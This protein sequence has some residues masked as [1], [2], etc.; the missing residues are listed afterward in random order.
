MNFNTLEFALFFPMVLV[1]LS[2][3]FR[4][5]RLRDGLLLLVSYLFYMAWYWQY[6]GLLVLSTLIDY[7]LGRRMET[8]QDPRRRKL[9]LS[10][11]L[12]LNLGILGFFK[13]YNFFTGLAS[14]SFRFFGYP[15]DFLRNPWLLPVGISFY[16]FQSLSYTI[17]VYRRR[18]PAEHSLVKFALFVAFFPQLVAG[19]IVRAADF[20]P[21][22]HRPLVVGRGRF[23]RGLTLIFIGLF[24]KIVFADALAS[25]GVD[26]VFDHPAG[27][28]SL[29][30]LMALY[31]YAFQIYCDFSGYSDIAIG[32][33]AMMGFWLPANFNRPYL[34]QNLREFWTR[35]H[36]SLS[37]WLK[38]YLYL[39]LGGN[40]GTP[41]Q[42]T[43]NLMLTM[44]LGGLWHG[45]AL[46]FLAWGLVH[47]L[48]LVLS[49]S[50]PRHPADQAAWRVWLNRA[51]TFHLVCFT[52]LLFRIH[53]YQDFL[54]YVGGLLALE[55]GTGLHPYFY[56][57]LALAA[58]S[59]LVPKQTLDRAWRQ[60]WIRA[61]ALVQAGVYAAL[62]LVFIGFS[63]ETPAFIYFQ[64]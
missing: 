46:N 43:R 29:D 45:A 50:Q 11:S 1:L 8:C 44:I 26:A 47:G 41:A 12:A 35:W 25:L 48:F 55:G 57:L 34:S 60:R 17:D 36:I 16:T 54:D 62:L 39:S 30:L 27:H 7:S 10:L 58:L 2:A 3:V 59:H 24:K 32:A 37:S 51:L 6:A 31:G 4:R 28:S 15:V 18:L 13:Y 21:Q 61:P 9:L 14:E 20:L 23:L 49:R 33:A 22:L 5:E 19:P 40:R 38:D 52:W 42:T 53:G 63:L 56:G 64:F